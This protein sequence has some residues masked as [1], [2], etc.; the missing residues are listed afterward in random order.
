[1]PNSMTRFSHL[2]ITTVLAAA[3]VIPTVTFADDAD[4]DKVLGADLGV[5]LPWTRVSTQGAIYES[6]RFGAESRLFVKDDDNHWRVYRGADYKRIVESNPDLG[7]ESGITILGRRLGIDLDIELPD[8]PDLPEP[9]IP[10][11]GTDDD[12]ADRPKVEKVTPAKPVHYRGAMTSYVVAPH[13]TYEMSSLHTPNRLYVRR[14]DAEYVYL[15]ENLDVIAKRYP[16]VKKHEGFDAFSK[17]VAHAHKVWRVKPRNKS[18]QYVRSWDKAGTYK[19]EVWN[20]ENGTWSQKTYVGSKL[21]EIVVKHEEARPVLH[22]WTTI[23]T[24][25][26][27][28]DSEAGMKTKTKDDSQE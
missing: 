26:V 22:T 21:D 9:P 2:F 7:A 11:P 15:G 24:P 16:Q 20:Y 10:L 17:R 25:A 1:M 3:L 5:D 4:D 8:L 6:P 19:V 14:G 28:V 18:T 12:E 23:E 27:E 13:M